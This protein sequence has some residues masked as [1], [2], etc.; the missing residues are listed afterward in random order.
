M[1]YPVICTNGTECSVY[2][3]DTLQQ[4]KDLVQCLYQKE[5]NSEYV[6]CNNIKN[7]HTNAWVEFTNDE[8]INIVIGKY[9]KFPFVYSSED[10]ND[11]IILVQYEW[12]MFRESENNGDFN[13]FRFERALKYHSG[14]SLIVYGK[15]I[16]SEEFFHVGIKNQNGNF[17]CAHLTDKAVP[18]E[19]IKA[20]NIVMDRFNKLL[21]DKE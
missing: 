5:L 17:V 8:T 1:A 2:D 19:L 12:L 9:E 16:N 7:D 13:K 20:I 6:S 11:L 21:K 18:E 4:A 10:I 14:F 15:N 3:C